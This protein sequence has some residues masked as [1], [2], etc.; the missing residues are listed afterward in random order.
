MLE[1]NLNYW[2]A[3]QRYPNLDPF[4]CIK[5]KTK[6]YYYTLRLTPVT[7][8]LYL[9]LKLEH[10]STVSADDDIQASQPVIVHQHFINTAKV[11]PCKF[12][13]AFS[14]NTKINTSVICK[15]H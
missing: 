5:R 8:A 9:S 14:T 15:I 10:F 6:T 1:R 11:I 4:L 13:P 3:E 7:H 2:I 12:S